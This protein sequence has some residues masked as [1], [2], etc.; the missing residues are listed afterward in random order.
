MFEE[1]RDRPAT[2]GDLNALQQETRA[3]VN[4]LRSDF[5][6]LR[7]D[8]KQLRDDFASLER[9]MD[10]RFDDLHRHFD[11]VAED[12]KTQFGNL[13][14]WTKATTTKLDGRVEHLEQDH[15]KRLASAELRLTRLESDR[16]PPA[17]APTGEFTP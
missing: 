14:D 10:T 5:T 16:Y 1:D 2:R 3:D 6:Q 7:G 12:F 13:F 4:G 17:D 9:R 8:F 15:G 11:V